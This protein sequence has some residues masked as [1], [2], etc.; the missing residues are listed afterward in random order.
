MR[1]FTLYILFT[2]FYIFVTFCYALT[3]NILVFFNTF[4][5][6]YFVC[7]NEKL[8]DV[9]SPYLLKSKKN[10]LLLFVL[11]HINFFKALKFYCNLF[12][13]KLQLKDGYSM[14]FQFCEGVLVKINLWTKPFFFLVMNR[15]E[16]GLALYCCLCPLWGDS[17]FSLYRCPLLLRKKVRKNPTF[18]SCPQNKR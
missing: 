12:P 6:A 9:L 1:I 2:Y 8:T 5:A 3:M 4:N 18:H 7:S 14:D 13:P 15:V 17:T 10:D 16:K 11:Q